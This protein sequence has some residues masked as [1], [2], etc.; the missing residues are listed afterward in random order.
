MVIS[1]LYHGCVMVVLWLCDITAV[2]LCLCHVAVV[3]AVALWS[4]DVMVVMAVAL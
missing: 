1:W 2:I 4:C 3:A